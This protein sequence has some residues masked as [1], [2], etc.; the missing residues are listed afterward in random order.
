MKALSELWISL[1]N[2]TAS[3]Q[4]VKVWRREKYRARLRSDIIHPADT[5]TTAR[6]VVQVRHTESNE[7]TDLKVSV[8]G[9]KKQGKTGKTSCAEFQRH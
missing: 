9:K 7:E 2:N 4:I 6:A 1:L 5:P 8:S 3:I